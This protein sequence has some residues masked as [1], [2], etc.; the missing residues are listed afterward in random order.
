MRDLA[1]VLN[2]TPAQFNV[3]WDSATSSITLTP[4]SYTPVG[5]EMVNTSTGRVMARPTTSQIFFAGQPVSPRG[6][7]IGGNNFFMLRDLGDILGF[8]VDWDGATR[9]VII[10]GWMNSDGHRR[11]IL[12]PSLRHIGAG[13]HLG[14]QWGVF[15]Y[16]LMR[17]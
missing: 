17:N 16:L 7:L 15:H 13:S 12:N 11:N 6:Y 9:T 4:G 10:D 5:G 2:G 8:G 3:G 14:G 1:Y